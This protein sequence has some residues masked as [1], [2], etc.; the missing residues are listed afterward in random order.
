[1]GVIAEMADDVVVMYLGRAVEKGPVDDIFHAPKHPYTRALLRSIPSIMAAPRTKL[2]TIGGSIP[3]PVQRGPPAARSIRAAP[4][5]CAACATRRC[6][7][8]WSRTSARE[9]SCFLYGGRP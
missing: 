9:V 4:N 3:H 5:S 7:R 1:M 2:A 6:R 8:C